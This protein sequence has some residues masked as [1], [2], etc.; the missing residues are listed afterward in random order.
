VS[1]SAVPA[2][3]SAWWWTFRAVL[4]LLSG[5]SLYLL[6]PSLVALFSS[7]PQLKTLKPQWFAAALFFEAMSFVSLWEVQRITLRTPS[8]F[9]VATSQLAGNA[10]GSL[11]PGGGATAGAFAYRL[12]VRAGVNPSTV[13]SG[14]TA[15]LLVTTSAVLGLPVLAIPAIIGG[16]A[17]AGGL[18]Q[19]A[20]IGAAAF[21]LLAAG[22]AAALFWDAPLAAAGRAVR[23]ALG[24]TRKAEAVADLPERL[25]RMRDEVRVAFGARW[26]SGIAGAVGKCGFDYLALVCCLAAVGS[27]PDPALVLLAYAAGALLAFIPLTPGGLGFVETGLTGMLAL[28]GVGAQAATVSTLAYR[29]VSFW[30][31]LPIGGVALL[32]YRRRYGAGATSTASTAP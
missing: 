6:W 2:Q 27:R 17:A 7:W 1:D 29:L 10:M 3:R 14:M 20:Y 21:V 23:W 15:S 9:A 28:A 5:V 8:W 19:T 31:P 26:K 18:V 12:L 22:G 30:L 11:V 4:L 25:L 32:L 13:A 16:T 24:R